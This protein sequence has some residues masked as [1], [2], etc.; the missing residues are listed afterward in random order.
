LLQ[1][2]ERWNLCVFFGFSRPDYSGLGEFLG[3]LEGLVAPGAGDDI[4]DGVG[5]GTEVE[6]DGGELGGGAALEEEDGIFRRDL[7]EGTEIGLGFFDDGL[8]FL[9]AVAHLHDAHA[10]SAPDVELR[11]GAAEDGLREGGGPSGEVEDALLGPGLGREGVMGLNLGRG[12]G[13][14]NGDGPERARRGC[15]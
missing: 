3:L 14:F 7:E 9:A 10:G 1:S 12:G 6:R 15:E 8:E 4:I 5:G 2:F 11:L 13:A